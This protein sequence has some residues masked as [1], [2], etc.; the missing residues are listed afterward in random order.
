MHHVRVTKAG[1]PGVHLIFIFQKINSLT[2]RKYLYIQYQTLKSNVG[3]AWS[4]MDI[5]SIRRLPMTLG[6]SHGSITSCVIGCHR[7]LLVAI[8]CNAWPTLLFSV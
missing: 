2:L 8:G 6:W 3:H 4:S 1:S 7:G 5:D